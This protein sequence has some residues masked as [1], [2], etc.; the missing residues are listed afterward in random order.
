MYM[1][2]G[3]HPKMQSSAR[4]AEQVTSASALQN[5]EVS[6]SEFATSARS[7]FWL[8]NVALPNGSTELSDTQLRELARRLGIEC[9]NVVEVMR[10]QIKWMSRLK[11]IGALDYNVVMLKP[12]QMAYYQHHKLHP[13]QPI[14]RVLVSDTGEFLLVRQNDADRKDE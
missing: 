9:S 11:S 13:N 14:G 6:Q 4:I 5:L 3:L 10:S 7:Y 8:R 1:L 2:V 12:K